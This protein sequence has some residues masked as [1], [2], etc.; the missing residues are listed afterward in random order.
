MSQQTQERA[1]EIYA[2]EILLTRGGWQSGSNAE[3]DKERA[4][5]PA[6]IFSFI[7][8]TQ[9]KLWAE[10]R[11]LHAAGLESLLITTLAWREL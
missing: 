5:F 10:M 2:E 11:T 1:F 7:E 3:W 9:P 6:R 8:E 4:L